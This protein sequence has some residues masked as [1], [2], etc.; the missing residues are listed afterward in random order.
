MM[1]RLVLK[2]W[3]GVTILQCL[4]RC[5]KIY[6]DSLRPVVHLFCVLLLMWL[7]LSVCPPVSV[8]HFVNLATRFHRTHRSSFRCS[9][10]SRVRATDRASRQPHGLQ[11]LQAA[12]EVLVRSDHPASGRATE[13]PTSCPQLTS[14]D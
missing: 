7:T 6:T 1:D 10:F 13:R 12:E 14:H 3:Q 8:M 9:M 11:E 4:R 2:A 5:A